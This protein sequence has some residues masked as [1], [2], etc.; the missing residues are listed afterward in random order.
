MESFNRLHKVLTSIAIALWIIGLSLGFLAWSAA[1]AVS[2]IV[3][4]TPPTTAD[5]TR[6]V[7]MPDG[8]KTTY[9]AIVEEIARRR[10]LGT[11]R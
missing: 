7:T 8:S 9:G 4:Q 11:M 1:E 10:A 2:R 5:L 6:V 3:P